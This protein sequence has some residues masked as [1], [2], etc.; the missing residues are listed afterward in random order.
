MKKTVLFYCMVWLAIFSWHCRKAEAPKEPITKNKVIYGRVID[1]TD[2][3]IVPSCVVGIYNVTFDGAFDRF[4]R[5]QEQRTGAD[6]AFEFHVTQQDN[7]R[8]FYLSVDE[9]P[10]G[11]SY[12][13][14]FP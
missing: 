10:D 12:D 11:Y 8:S 6:G 13:A 2:N 4:T 5:I 1:R 3:T 7:T 14:Y 9:G